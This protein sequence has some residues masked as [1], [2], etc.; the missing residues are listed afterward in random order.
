MQNLVTVEQALKKGRF[1]LVY[2]PMI[3]TFGIIG[4][5]F[6][7]SGKYFFGGWIIPVSFLV[8]FIFGWLSWSYFVVEWKIWAYENVRNIHELQRKAVEEK[9]IWNTGSWFEKTEFKN[10][11]QKQKLKQLEK[12]F[13]EKDS[14]KDDVS[15]PKETIIFYSRSAILFLIVI[16]L[17]ISFLGI[18]F[19]LEKEYF[20]LL[21]LGFG[22]YLS[23]EQFK[24]IRDKSPQI[25]INDKG[26]KLKNENLTSWSRIYNDRVYVQSNGKK[27]TSYLA[28]NNEKIQID[29]LSIRFEKLEN[30]LHV[31]RVRFEKN[32]S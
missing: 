15:V 17:G 13:L 21:F 22:L 29:D 14:Y 3:L 2:L 31:Y 19:L 23:Y 6:F 16:Y 4:L 8:G 28:F 11:E 7:L 9:L 12:K 5:G 32:N 18:Y 24:K 30:L 10:Y 26:I 25:V 27:S 20:G 1:K